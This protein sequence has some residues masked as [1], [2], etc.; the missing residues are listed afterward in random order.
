MATLYLSL[1]NRQISTTNQSF[2]MGIINA[3]KNSFW[4]G[5]QFTKQRAINKALKM[6]DEGADIL[7]IGAESSRPGASYISEKEEIKALIPIIKG[8]RKKSNIPISIDTRKTNVMKA[9]FEEGADILNDISALEDDEN[10]A[11]FVA[12]TNIN[13][14]LMHKQGNPSTM[15]NNPQ[16]SDI[17]N[18]ISD[19]LLKRC[20]YGISKG[21]SPEKIILDA[22]IG[23]GKNL[24]HNKKLILSSSKILQNIQNG[25]K[26]MGE[27]LPKHIVMALSRKTCIG[28][29]TFKKPEERLAGT[30]AANLIAVEKGATI[31]RVHDVKETK[32]MLFVYRG[33]HE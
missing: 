27:N 33:L 2:I 23:F 25:L 22:G 18:E 3:N 5:S 7:D 8:I 15:Q 19:Y 28:E 11:S 31:L 16:Y 12:K 30:I 21:I 14:I 24:D 10:M 4:K 13:C 20:Q 9:C 32:D 17:V 26:Y 1:H 6:I 29:M